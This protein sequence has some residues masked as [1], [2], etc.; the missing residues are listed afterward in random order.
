MKGSSGRK[1]CQEM[2]WIREYWVGDKS[3]LFVRDE[4]ALDLFEWV[5]SRHGIGSPPPEDLVGHPFFMALHRECADTLVGT[6]DTWFGLVEAAH[7]FEF[8]SLK[9]LQYRR[10]FRPCADADGKRPLGYQFIIL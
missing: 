6:Y 3:S 10:I 9:E 1:V 2:T 8:D 4:L 5:T 7:Q